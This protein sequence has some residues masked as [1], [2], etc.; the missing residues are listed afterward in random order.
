M[1]DKGGPVLAI[2]RPI[3]QVI[4]YYPRCVRLIWDAAKLDA[5]LAFAVS[6]LGAVVP[7]AQV[8]ITKIVID[9]VVSAVG[10]RGGAAVDWIGLLIPVAG[11]FS[12]WILGSICGA[13]AN[14]LLEKVGYLVSNHSQ[15]LILRKA[16]QLDIAFFE[17]SAFFDEME[18]ARSEIYRAHNLA[19]LPL[20]IV[21]SLTGLT[22][23]L[24]VLLSVH[25]AAPI[26]LLV[27]SAPQVI[28]GGHYA[29]KRFSL[30]GAVASNRRM[31]EYMSRLLG[32]R[33]AVKEIRIFALHEELL[34]RFSNFWGLFGKEAF[35]LR[36]AEERF[37][38]LLGLITMMGTASIW[39][40][41]VVRAVGGY[42]S[43]GTVALAFQAA[44]QARSGFSSLFRN[45]G[46]FYEH[47][48]FAGILFRFLD[49]DPR[50]VEG[51]LAPPPASPIPVPDRLTQSIEFRNVSFRYPGSDKYVLKNI[52]FTIR[53]R[54]SVAVVGENGAG[55][56]TV[57][58][59]LTRFYDP[60]EG[61]IYLDGR[62]L[63]EYDLAS[64][65]HQIGVIFQ[66][67]VRY[68][69]SA[70]ENVGFGQV[71]LLDDADRIERA[72]Y[73]GGA[74]DLIS[75]LPKG[76]DTI[77][78]KEFDEGV[79][80]SGGE[81]QKIALSRAFMKEAEVLILDEPT[82]ALDAFAERDVF[83]RFAE[84]TSDRTAIFI[85]H[86][87]STVRMADHILVLQQGELVEQGSHEQLLAENGRYAQMFN[88]Q[89]KQYR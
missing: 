85:S 8:W 13:A 38:F 9:N 35:R 34:R 43:V 4:E 68:D 14:G 51:A 50:S 72:A 87:F 22:A 25:W 19:I 75:R 54:E 84:L 89:A 80:L 73:E 69:L 49:L 29:G 12:V 16:A 21:S 44:E 82:A 58:K 63:R 77:L 79:D 39:A 45:L 64:L 41:A 32:S 59:L 6:M 52:S 20:L 24:A 37:S 56:T 42:I 47:T 71:D 83:S 66:D 5:I 60:T 30:Y 7:A 76:Y 48:I 65:R 53:V 11:I 46:L 2:L 81:W 86:R 15:Y 62:D 31:A 78:G 67:F 10:D 33:E 40:Y 28:V 74:S 57:V 55:K 1:S 3:A 26:I 70:K 17:N 36:F 88:T 61:A 23:M 27:T 18:K